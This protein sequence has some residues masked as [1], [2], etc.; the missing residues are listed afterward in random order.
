MAV[1]EHNAV[2]KTDKRAVCVVS[3]LRENGWRMLS[4][5]LCAI[6]NSHKH[7]NTCKRE[8]KGTSRLLEF[9]CFAPGVYDCYRTGP[10]AKSSEVSHFLHSIREID[11]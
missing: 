7:V 4:F 2:T 3:M 8:I 10:N 9:H 11:S 6:L 5:L 1:C